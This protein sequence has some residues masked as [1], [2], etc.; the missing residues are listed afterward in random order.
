MPASNCPALAQVASTV[1]SDQRRHV[2]WWESNMWHETLLYIYI[3]IYIYVSLYSISSTSTVWPSPSFSSCPRTTIDLQISCKVI[4]RLPYLQYPL[5]AIISVFF[6]PA[7]WCNQPCVATQKLYSETAMIDLCGLHTWLPSYRK[8]TSDSHIDQA[9]CAWPVAH[10]Q[11]QALHPGP[12]LQCLGPWAQYAPWFQCGPAGRACHQS[13]LWAASVLLG[14]RAAAAAAACAMIT[15]GQCRELQRENALAN[16]TPWTTHMHSACNSATLLPSY[17][18]CHSPGI[19]T[20]KCLS[21][22]VYRSCSYTCPAY[23]FMS[24]HELLI[25]HVLAPTFSRLLVSWFSAVR[26]LHQKMRR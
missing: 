12:P 5:Q 22:I 15:Q 23:M 8:K 9:F 4:D 10:L 13:A 7:S 21:D 1:P 24:I 19:H 17:T 6:I 18:F 25:W 16:E 26:R 14:A 20:A 11:R 2:N 3:Y